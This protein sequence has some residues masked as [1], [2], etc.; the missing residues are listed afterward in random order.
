MIFN[1]K[2]RRSDGTVVDGKIEAVNMNMAVDTLAATQLKVIEIKPDK[3]DLANYTAAI[4]GVDPYIVAVMTR[5]MAAMV[6]AGLP[7]TR[8]ISILYEQEEDR[9]LKSTLQQILHDIRIGSSLSWA[10]SKHRKIFENIY[11]SMVKVGETTG[12]MGGMLE[13]LADFLEKDIRIK[14]QA[15]SA[16]T[17]PAFIFT[18]CIAVVGAI[19]VYVLPGMLDMFEGMNAELPLPTKIMIAIVKTTKNR[20][21]QIGVVMGIFYYAIY[22]KDWLR[23]AHGKYRFDRFKLTIP[24]AKDINKKFLIS[25]FTRA[26]GVL[27][28]SGV[29]LTKSLEVLMDFIDNEY[30]KQVI[31]QP[32][33]DR[34]R[35]GEALSEIFIDL[36]FF[37]KMTTQM[38]SVGES[39]GELPLML[40]KIAIFYD[41][42]IQY[43]MEAFLVM[44]EP[45]MIGFLGM[46]VCFVLLAVFIPMYSV[47]MNMA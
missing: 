6:N 27:L 22:F 39:T 2:A 41:Q 18:F 34:I 9:K 29:P 1:Y 14:R 5:R 38:I 15:K 20:Y 25:N 23:T 28:N 37:P 32:T 8:T 35:E 43:A 40:D 17:Y 36:D 46:V 30:F 33:Y 31:I 16:L 10:L 45:I 44:L 19:F 4:G 3:Y 42:E 26:M 47:I 21:V 7:I 11:I 24:V 12:E 13:R